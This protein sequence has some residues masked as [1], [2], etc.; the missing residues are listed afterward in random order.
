MLKH[1]D[2]CINSSRKGI[3]RN[4]LLLQDGEDYWLCNDEA[5]WVH[6]AILSTYLSYTEERLIIKDR[7]L[8][9]FV[10][11]IQST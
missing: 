2:A 7:W 9:V 1:G 5:V 11:E 4:S 3:D 10:T 8:T 6:H